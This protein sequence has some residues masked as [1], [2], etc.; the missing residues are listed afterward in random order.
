[1]HCVIPFNNS[2]PKCV[3]RVTLNIERRPVNND[4]VQEEKNQIL[5]YHETK[6]W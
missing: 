2:A 6:V 5:A 3:E 4:R 1:M